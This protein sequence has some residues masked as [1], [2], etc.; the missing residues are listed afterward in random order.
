MKGKTKYIVPG[1]IDSE[2]KE[3]ID[4]KNLDYKK[5]PYVEIDVVDDY[6][7]INET[8][9]D[10]LL[11]VLEHAL[12]PE[13]IEVINEF[14]EVLLDYNI[15]HDF[16]VYLNKY[17][18][19]RNSIYTLIIMSIFLKTYSNIIKGL[20]IKDILFAYIF[21]EYGRNAKD[22]RVLNKI[23]SFA[24]RTYENLK[25]DFGNI[26][27][28]L[29]ESYDANYY[30]VYSYL[31]LKNAK[32]DQSVLDIILYSFEK[33]LTLE[34]PLQVSVESLES[35]TLKESV[36]VIRATE[37]YGFL[38]NLSIDNSIIPFDGIENNLTKAIN[39]GIINSLTVNILLQTVPVYQKNDKV[40]LSDQTLGIVKET[41]YKDILNPIVLDLEGNKINLRNS[42]L[43]IIGIEK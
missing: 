15:K 29:L 42:P 9:I 12:L 36:R 3:T 38:L 40:R 19:T 5:T 31:I 25:N 35:N 32:I 17:D 34:G 18:S 43:H 6:G 33:E 1:L 20:N 7:Y 28:D 27:N 11:N 14:I 24:T 21:K 16:N 4:I 22:K 13:Q 26:P 10:Y 2:T 30:N 41:N 23:K 8:V 39:A 37:L